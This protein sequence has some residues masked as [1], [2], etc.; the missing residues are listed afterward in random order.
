MKEKLLDYKAND[1]LVKF[2]VGSHKPGSGSAAALQGLLS[3]QLIRTVV[4]IS[5]KKTR[6]KSHFG[7]LEEIKEKID[8]RIYP[9]L[10]QF[11]QEDSDL[12]DLAVNLRIK[13][14]KETERKKALLL[15]EKA[16]E[17]LIPSTEM[18]IE[19]GKLCVELSD[20][21][22]FIFDNC[23]E[24]VRGDSG[25]SLTGAHAAL[26]G[27]IF[28]IDLNLSSFPKDSWTDDIIS[29][30]DYL[31]QE[32]K[33]ISEGI[34]LRHLLLRKESLKKNEYLA[35]VQ[36]LKSFKGQKI[37]YNEIEKLANKLLNT[38]HL[39]KEFIW[40]KDLPED[41]IELINPR[42]ILDVLGY[43]YNSTMSLGEFQ[44]KGNTVEIAG[45]ID[46][47]NRTISVSEQFSNDIQ[48]FTVA[49]EIGH[50]LLHNDLVLHR[51]RPL[52][53]SKEPKEL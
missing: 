29:D 52:N 36:Y 12:F 19:I 51:D 37:T 11:F 39:H 20:F 27:C 53:G 14:N 18:P 33:N 21:A 15:K 31:R 40:K 42:K 49:H 1:L 4:N 17:K 44:Q 6:F 5:L 23:Y 43:K 48:K 13:R 30:T 9:T 7:K 47:E 16:L 10:Q 22:F 50:A 41:S 38:L 26:G 35:K 46:Q 2:G 25:V 45:I 34:G 8:N 24:A 28:I 3:A 32:Y